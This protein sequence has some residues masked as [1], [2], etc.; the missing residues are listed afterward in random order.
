MGEEIV[1][2]LSVEFP[3]LQ[4]LFGTVQR[5]KALYQRARGR[6]S[7]SLR[8]SLICELDYA[9]VMARG[10]DPKVRG[11]QRV[12]NSVLRAAKLPLVTKHD[13]ARV[14]AQHEQ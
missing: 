9:Y 5:R 6:S 10:G 11:F 1:E 2:S 14:Q 4:R 7:D 13:M 12:A 8:T 3:E